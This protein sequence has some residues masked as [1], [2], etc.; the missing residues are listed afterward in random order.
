[1][2]VSSLQPPAVRVLIVED[3]GLMRNFLADWLA[4]R[5]RFVLAGLARTGEEALEQIEAG[6]PD[7]ALVDFQLPGMDGLEFIRTARQVRPQLRALVVSSL[8][9]PLSLTRIHESGVEGYLEKD[10]HP[11]LLELALIAVAEGQTCFSA[12]FQETLAQQRS[13]VDGVG[14]ILSRREQQVLELVLSGRPNREIAQF[15]D[16]SQRTVEFHRANVMAKL[17]ANNLIEMKTNA[18]LRGWI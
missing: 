1:M 18:Q 13:Q 8:V 2:K 6:R 14:K 10:A 7:V 15:L 5:P 12:K 17:D 4:E 11:R 3:Q 16:L 9:D